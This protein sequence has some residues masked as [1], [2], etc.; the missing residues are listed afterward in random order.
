MISSVKNI[1]QADLV[2][3][4]RDGDQ[5]HYLRA[6]RLCLEIL[7]FGTSLVAITIEGTSPDEE[8]TDG[9]NV[10]DLALY[11]G[12]TAPGSASQI[13]Y[14][15][16][17]HSTLHAAEE[18]T[19]SGFKKT[20]K[21]FAA[22][23]EKLV[24]SYG[25]EDVG[26]RFSF[27][28]ETNRP[29]A[30]T[31]FEALSDLAEGQE[32]KRSAYFRRELP[33]T[34]SALQNFAK[35]VHLMPSVP[36][37]LTQR[38]LLEQG[39]GTYLPDSDKD[40]P[41]KL[42]DLV[43]RKATT[44]FERNPQIR[45]QDVLDAID[46]RE[47]SL[48]PAPSLIEI[49]QQIV[50]REQLPSIAAAIIASADPII[51][52][53]EGGVGKSVT[54]TTLARQLPSGSFG[55]VYD[56][57]GNGGYRS[58]S[59]Y[60]HRPQDGLVQLVNEMASAG[61]CDP[62]LPSNKADD[63]AYVRAFL[64]RVRQAA[65][66]LTKSGDGLLLIVIDA[67]DNAET[68][69]Q[70]ASDGPSF[71]RLLLREKLPANVRLVLTA[72][73]YRVGS[74]APPPEVKLTTLQPFSE[75]ETAAK[76][77]AHFSD[78]APADVREFH[79]LTSHNPRVQS[80]ALAVGD[81]VQE[82]LA[83][84][85]PTPRTVEDTIKELLEKAIAKAR[86]VSAYE[87]QQIDLVCT[88]LAT[89]RPFVPLEIVAA[90]AGVGVELVRSIAND[91]QRPLIVRED[92]VQFRD[93][94]TETWFRQ[95]FRPSG[96]ELNAFISR[97]KP[98]AVESAYVAAVLPA[99]MLE[100]GLFDEL[101]ALALTSEALPQG[102]AIAKRDVELQRL[103]FALK[104]ALRSKRYFEAIKLAMKAGGEAATD[105]RQQ[106]LLNQNT[107]LAARFLEPNQILE[108]VSRRLI[109][110]GS[111]TGSE[112]AYEAALLSSSPQLVGDARSRLRFAYE[113]VGHWSRSRKSQEEDHFDRTS[114]DD[115]DIAALQLAELNLHGAAIC[116]Q[117]LRRWTPREVSFRVGRLLARRLVDAGRFTE[118]DELAHEAGN[119]LGLILAITMEL[120]GIGRVPPREAVQ[121]AAAL[122]ASKHVKIDAPN[123]WRGE[124]TRLIAVSE[125]VA[126]ATKLRIA[127]RRDL[128]RV[129]DR[130]IPK[131]APRGLATRFPHEHDRRL[132]Y[133][134]AY[135]LRAKLR[136]RSVH[137]TEPAE[138]EIKKAL[139]SKH[140]G[141][142]S[143]AERYK[144][145]IGVL[146][147]WHDLWAGGLLKKI[148]PIDLSAAIDQARDRANQAEARSYEEYSA[149][150]DEIAHIWSQILVAV[151]APEAEWLKLDAWRK[152]LKH[153]LFTPTLTAIARRAAFLGQHGFA[154]DIAA[155]AH[156]LSAGE[157]DEAD[158][159]ADG[160]ISVC[161]AVLTSSE[162]EAGQYFNEAIVVA[163]RIGSENLHRWEAILHLAS[164][165]AAAPMDDPE[166]AY[167]FARA[168]EL[169]YEYVARDRHFPWD[170][171]VEALTGL[172]HRS[173]PAIISRWLDRHFGNEFRILPEL[174]EALRDGGHLD[175]IASLC[176]LPMRGWWN[177]LTVLKAALNGADGKTERTSIATAFLRYARF[178][179]GSAS[180]WREI[181]KILD[182]LEFPSAIAH[183]M[184][185][186][187]SRSEE[188]EQRSKTTYYSTETEAIDWDTV[189]NETD[190]LDPVSMNDALARYKKLEGGFY[191]SRFYEAAI[192]RLKAG[193]EA[194]FL[195]SLAR[196][197]TV[198]RYEL[199]GLLD[200]IPTTWESRVSVAPA[201]QALVKQVYRLECFSITASR[202]YQSLPHKLASE[203]SGLTVREL[204]A[205]AVDAI[206]QTTVP[207]GADDLFQLVGVLA[208]FLSV[209][210]AREALS[211][212]LNLLEPLHEASDGDGPWSIDLVPPSTVEASIAGYLW[213]ALGSPAAER[214]WNAAHSI[215]MLASLDRTVVIDHL[216]KFASQR[217]AGPF[218]DVELRFYDLH[219]VQWFAISLA[220]AA[221]ES[222]ATIARCKTYLLNQTSPNNQH[223]LTRSFAAEA[224]LT[225]HQSEAILLEQEQ[226]DALSAINK[227]K[228]PVVDS[229]SFGRARKGRPTERKWDD[230]RF[231]FG[232]DFPKYFL[233]PLGNAFAISDAEMEIEAEKII[234]DDW[235]LADNGRYDKDVRAT[236]KY[237]RDNDRRM[238]GEASAVDDLQFYLSYHAT[239][240]LA[241][242]LLDEHPLHENLQEPD[243][244]W[245]TFRRWLR[246]Q[247]LTRSDGLWLADRRDVSPKECV[248]LSATKDEDWPSSL[249]DER[250]DRFSLLP[251]ARVVASGRWTAYASRR[252]QEISV[253]SAFVSKETAPALVRALQN[254]EDRYF[255]RL[256]YS[257]EEDGE[258][259]K[260][261]YLLKGWVSEFGRDE[262]GLDKFDAWAANVGHR[263]LAPSQNIVAQM[264]LEPDATD[265][266][267]QM[268]GT[269]AF[270]SEIWSE[271]SPDEDG[272]HSHG[273]RLLIHPPLIDGL[274]K[275][276]GMSLIVEVRAERQMAYSRY[277]RWK[278]REGRDAR[279]TTQIILFEEDKEPVSV[280]SDPKPRPQA[281]RRSKGR[282]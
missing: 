154:L 279:S 50:A 76:L 242:K 65:D 177:L 101:V 255:H 135:S 188:R 32:S 79:R 204:L 81:T 57:F 33:L 251:D 104:A 68:A 20:L 274:L 45:R 3:T 231:H 246:S 273:R 78:V 262:E 267:W 173:G 123:D 200:A 238:R 272:Q 59:E 27:E 239:M 186:A 55:F 185:E 8:I 281:R 52:Q 250:V 56:C 225:L 211:Y 264:G 269:A 148:I 216:M 22:R 213:A 158:S 210:Q 90:T 36:D 220:R 208:T 131:E 48:F 110:G 202:Y 4:S 127:P 191:P 38:S 280:R 19:D 252:R 134:R 2:R 102:S 66:Q 270:S 140:G 23:Y 161:R 240:T 91:L 107:D 258:L 145:D 39:L 106:N 142:G 80:A 116:A 143:D 133:L 120:G 61:L 138:P 230:S 165:S 14:R 118:L 176:L 92:A 236:R 182:A 69:S 132:A 243:D 88:A 226:V 265:R 51:I 241:G 18:W 170:H 139:K 217:S 178:K 95:R 25:A 162:A 160:L 125:L 130:Y 275:K 67:A 21:G 223:V 174:V 29:I 105:E 128:A 58:A 137:L 157:R 100:A 63:S 235:G 98:L 198:E 195:E 233:S 6:A 11:H 74:L 214:R 249:D 171:T 260:G 222:P 155:E 54:A 215:R 153:P 221:Q 94:P 253:R 147:P 276:T 169:T 112:H 9:L 268:N 183:E 179:G 31:V 99:L 93:E 172:S 124:D 229:K 207:S 84:L 121:R 37:Y 34:G 96:T 28:F 72:R 206:G 212:A 187:A 15:Q 224:L 227:S 75:S 62:L 277:D 17:K 7:R 126:A 189:F 152:E 218:A 111:W 53:A 16:F 44:E 87:Q 42:K 266:T 175:P 149:T 199:R 136:G 43:T 228:L 73:P 282:R 82:V 156:K 97:L 103:Q 71:P 129:L 197:G 194:N 167:R 24:E 47:H 245:R 247:G 248:S 49:P 261:N 35:L 150:G 254:S 164:A 232:L 263:T 115:E 114:I 166:T 89:L 83:Q 108:Q 12:S 26:K 271:G 205:E 64:S 86:D 180:D 85:G 168:A 60:R 193:S 46:A 10:I 13:A 257:D 70:E 219:A 234:R 237:F 40:A 146:L 77:R 209:E 141:Y 203:A 5:F 122:L 256:P 159:K 30:A 201:I 181:G 117:Q 163:S 1:S 259:S 109:T 151:A 192:D 144:R 41:L 196:S 244:D 113:W 190:L 119:D 278:E 184:I